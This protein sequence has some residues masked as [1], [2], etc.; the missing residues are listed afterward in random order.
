MGCWIARH[1]E[2]SRPVVAQSR[3]CAWL[4]ASPDKFL[5]EDGRFLAEDNR[6]CALTSA[7]AVSEES[8]AS[9]SD[10]TDEEMKMSWMF[11]DKRQVRR[12][13]IANVEAGRIAQRDLQ[14]EEE[15]IFCKPS[16]PIE[17]RN[18]MRLRHRADRDALDQ[19]HWGSFSL[20]CGM[21]FALKNRDK[22]RRQFE[23][24]DKMMA[25]NL[26][27]THAK[28][29]AVFAA[30]TGEGSTERRQA[31]LNRHAK[32]KAYLASIIAHTYEERCGL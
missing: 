8:D 12:N 16:A 3:R 27:A 19:V 11:V 31:L 24:V 2:G 25:A 18:W 6:F 4:M 21:P 15:S 7:I 1:R 22:L 30:D 32:E 10:A 13:M 29:W 23:A 5:A 26:E 20:D 14:A 17:L 28:D 9:S